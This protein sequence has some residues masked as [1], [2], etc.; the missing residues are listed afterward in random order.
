MRKRAATRRWGGLE[1]CDDGNAEDGDGCSSECM[2]EVG[3]SCTHYA[4][5]PYPCGT[6]ADV[7]RPVCGDGLLLGS[8]VDDAGYCDDGNLVSGDGC[9]SGCR[10]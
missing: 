2:I 1:E 3:Y 9:S 6:Y 5:P 4:V 7:C 10:E 8:E